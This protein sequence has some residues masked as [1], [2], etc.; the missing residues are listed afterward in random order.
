[1]VSIRKAGELMKRSFLFTSLL[2]AALSICATAGSIEGKVSG[3]SGKSVVYVDT[4]PGKAFAPP[5]QHFLMGQQGLSF[6]PHVLA[7]SV[8]STVDFQNNDNVQ[9]NIF[10]PSIGG[11]KK[12]GHNLGTWPK[13]DKR[14]FKFDQAG[15]VPLFCNVHAEMSG[16]IVV[17]PTPYYAE[18]DTSGAYKIDNVPDGKY[19]VVAW[20]EG[21][22]PQ[23]KPVDVAGTGKADFTLSK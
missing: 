8:G 16:F 22:K 4:I 9:H 23:T 3:V 20:H 12:L 6:Q 5:A 2:V 18:T 14:S 10:W 11:N 17:S 15:V 7:V 1:M 21:A 13:G 19:N